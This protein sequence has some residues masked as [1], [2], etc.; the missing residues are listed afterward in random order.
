MARRGP[1]LSVPGLRC[2]RRRVL[3]TVCGPSG[4]VKAARILCEQGNDES[5]WA[6]CVALPLL[7]LFGLSI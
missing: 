2:T 7:V 5:G 4:E 6:L 3:L 1:P